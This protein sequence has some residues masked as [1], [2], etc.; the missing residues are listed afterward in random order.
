MQ[1]M[2]FGFVV[3]Y[4]KVCH[5]LSNECLNHRCF[6]STLIFTFSSK[7]LLHPLIV[8]NDA[9][10]FVWANTRR[11]KSI[12]VRLSKLEKKGWRPRRIIIVCSWDVEEFV[13]VPDPDNRSHT[14]YDYM[15]HQNPPVGTLLSSTLESLHLTSLM[16]YI[17]A[18][19]D[20]DDWGIKAFPGIV[21]NSQLRRR[22]MNAEERLKIT[23]A[24]LPLVMY[25]CCI[26]T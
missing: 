7:G 4:H 13:V 6:N 22:S 23:V 17:Y 2:I 18:L 9:G 24:P 5:L 1:M 15:I 14:L 21:S 11:G 8:I 12:G 20:Q 19:P 26:W 16:D 10:P 25:I 3:C